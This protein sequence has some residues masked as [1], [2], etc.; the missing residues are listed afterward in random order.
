MLQLLQWPTLQERCYK[1]RLSLLYKVQNNLVALQIPP[2]YRKCRNETR[3]HH[4]LS[5]ILPYIRTS[6]YMNSF[7]PRTINEW[8]ALPSHVVRSN[9]LT[10]FLDN[11]YVIFLDFFFLVV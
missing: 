8:N 6:A 7:Y 1:S 2:Y 11:V 3:L 9:S 5:F 4:Q 10:E